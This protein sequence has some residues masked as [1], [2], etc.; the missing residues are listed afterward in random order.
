M[1]R[2][3]HSVLTRDRAP[4]PP[5]QRSINVALVVAFFYGVLFTTYL[6]HHK[7]AE[8]ALIGRRSLARGHGTSP[9][10]D[11]LARYAHHPVG[12]DGQFALF[13][14]RDPVHAHRYLDDPVY[15]LD[16]ILYPILSRALA[17]GQPGAIPVTLL[18]VNILAV[19]A[20]TFSLALFL[21]RHGASPWLA[22]LL[23][24][25]P[26][27][28]VGVDRDL[29]EPLAFALVIA[30]LLL[31]DSGRWLWGALLLGLAGITRE[32]TSDL[33]RCAP[34]RGGDRRWADPSARFRS[35]RIRGDRISPF[36]L[37]HAFLLAEYGS[38]PKGDPTL[39]LIPFQGLFGR[40]PWGAAE[41]E[42]VYAV[43]VPLTLRARPDSAAGTSTRRV[44]TRPRAERSRI[45]RPAAEPLVRGLRRLGKDHARRP[46]RVHHVH[47]SIPAQRSGSCGYTT[48]AAVATSPGDLVGVRHPLDQ[49]RP[50]P[51]PRKHSVL[52]LDPVCIPSAMN[53]RYPKDAPWQARRTLCSLDCRVCCHGGDHVDG[54]DLL[55]GAR[56]AARFVRMQWAT[57]S[58]Y[59]PSYSTTT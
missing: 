12:Y 56:K 59:P 57:T 55:G 11:A 53:A 40:L 27:V 35:H 5:F 6:R 28:F 36:V 14:A 32:T 13:I 30:A 58:T 2:Q 52:S 47:P 21:I 22:L 15:R 26:A 25:S 44:D 8:L 1:K 41:L 23:G 38:N 48:S 33:C 7:A 42:E 45:C 18:V 43:V 10:I 3:S 24:L 50:Q 54:L 51:R 49:I 29:N 20:G 19:L 34:D 39:T 9:G 17:L 4:A 46:D 37:V 31:V 16:R